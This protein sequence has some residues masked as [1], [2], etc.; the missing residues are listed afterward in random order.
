[1]Y[2]IK[3]KDERFMLCKIANSMEEAITLRDKANNDYP[4]QDYHIF[5]YTTHKMLD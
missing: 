4:T 2:T 5:D 3:S 1:M